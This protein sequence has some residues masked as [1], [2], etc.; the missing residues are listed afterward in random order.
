MLDEAGAIYLYGK[1]NA[2]LAAGS[3]VSI[4][5]SNVT[6][7]GTVRLDTR[8]VYMG[9]DTSLHMDISG[10]ETM[11]WTTTDSNN[12][13]FRL[14]IYANT[15]GWGCEYHFLRHSQYRNNKQVF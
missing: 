7:Y 10:G 14:N 3:A 1:N 2:T 5:A 15:T 9:W 8:N 13:R 4:Y 11:L 12:Y 6:L